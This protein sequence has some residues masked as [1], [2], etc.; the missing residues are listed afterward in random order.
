MFTVEYSVRAGRMAAYQLTG[1]TKK[2][3]PNVS[4]HDRGIGILLKAL[5]KSYKGGAGVEIVRQQ[6]PSLIRKA[7]RMGVVGG[8]AALVGT[9]FI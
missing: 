3:I 6:K 5:V 4:R 1:Q 2:R 9:K 7:L 8:I